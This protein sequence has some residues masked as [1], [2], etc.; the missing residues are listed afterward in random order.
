MLARE[1]RDFYYKEFDPVTHKYQMIGL[2]DSVHLATAIIFQATELHTRDKRRSGGN[3]GLLG[4][5]AFSPDGKIAGQWQLKIV[6]P[7]DP[8]PQWFDHAPEISG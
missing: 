3:L 4:L 1:I 8:E 5:N 7:E 6:D 2:G